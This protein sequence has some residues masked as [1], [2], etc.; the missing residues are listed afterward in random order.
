MRTDGRTKSLIQFQRFYGDLIH[1]HQCNALKSSWVRYV[2][3]ILA[4]FGSSRQIFIEQYHISRKCGKDLHY[5]WNWQVTRM[6][7]QT[8]FDLRKLKTMTK[9]D[10][11]FSQRCYWRFK[12]SGMWRRVGWLSYIF[13]VLRNIGRPKYVPIDTVLR[14][15]T[16]E[17]S[18]VPGTVQEHT[19]LSVSNSSAF[20]KY[21]SDRKIFVMAST[22]I[23]RNS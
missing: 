7:P 1:R 6:T 9:Q 3:Q 2:C 5:I 11:E 21:F 12:P 4:K 22:Q 14:S 15:R 18:T 17:S 16:L 19:R 10:S 13:W 23:L 20:A 8:N